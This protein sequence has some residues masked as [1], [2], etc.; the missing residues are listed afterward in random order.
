MRRLRCS[1]RCWWRVDRAGRRLRLARFWQAHGD[2]D[3]AAGHGDHAFR[4]LQGCGCASARP[5]LLAEVA[6]TLAQIDR[7]RAAYAA[8][9]DRLQ[10]LVRLLDAAPMCTDRNRLLV[11]ALIALGDVHRRA[12]RYDQVGPVLDRAI[13]LVEHGDPGGSQPLA[14][15]LTVLGMTAKELGEFDRAA[16]YYDRVGR[17]HQ[18]FGAT[19]A[20]AAALAH[21][22]AGLAYAQQMFR[23]AE[24]HARDAVALRQRVPGRSKVA[25]AE[26]V[27]V[28]AA[29]IAGQHR[30]DEARALLNEAM[31]ICRAA[32]PSR[33]YEVAVHLHNLAAI[34]QS[35]GELVEAERLYRQ[36]LALKEQLLGAD[37]PEIA[38]V[39][40]NLGTL[41]RDQHREAEAVASFRW[42]LDIAERTLPSDHVTTTTVRQNLDRL[43]QLLTRNPNM[44]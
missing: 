5:T 2:L 18:E 6:L 38:L 41:L 28:L 30:Y 14:A 16:D 26:D 29:A 9:H 21:N 24:S 1:V 8:S 23:Q 10:W 36:A 39:A 25:L 17:I 32:R 37:H 40:N 13:R 12:G 43:A 35:C 33:L 7:D 4:L 22:L 34:H 3:E 44:P 11:G 27:A 20:N 31:E 42:A 19:H 15:L